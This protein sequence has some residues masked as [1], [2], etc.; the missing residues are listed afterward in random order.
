MSEV[1]VVFCDAFVLHGAGPPVSSSE[2]RSAFACLSA[3]SSLYGHSMCLGQAIVRLGLC[4]F[5]FGGMWTSSF[6]RFTPHLC[7]IPSMHGSCTRCLFAGWF[8]HELVFSGLS[9]PTLDKPFWLDVGNNSL[10]LSAGRDP[11]A[12]HHHHHRKFPLYGGPRSFFF[13]L[14]LAFFAFFAFIFYGSRVSSC[15]KS[16]PSAT[17]MSCVDRQRTSGD[18]T[19][20]WRWQFTLQTA[21]SRVSRT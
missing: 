21:R 10:S 13:S 12:V 18:A 4:M 14:S 9:W 8:A 16:Q 17:A 5:D 3:S 11:I 6:G 19:T 15:R 2:G 20:A 7:L 1:A